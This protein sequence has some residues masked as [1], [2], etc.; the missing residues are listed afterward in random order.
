M[1]ETTLDKSHAAMQAAPENDALRLR[2]YEDLCDADVY[3]LLD[4]EPEGDSVKP[5]VVEMEGAPF[6]LIFD[7]EDRLSD[8]TGRVAPYAGLPGRALVQMM[9]GQGCGLALNLRVASSAMLIPADGVD[10]L[11]TTLDHAP[12][13]TQARLVAI[14]PPKSLPEAVLDALDRKLSKTAGLAETAYLVAAEYEDGGKG[15]VLGFVGADDSAHGAL[16]HAAGEALTF[17]GIDAGTMDVVFIGADE[18]MARRLERVGLR[19]DLPKIQRV[20]PD[21]PMAPGADP[22][23][24]PKLR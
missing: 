1:T 11:A 12:E 3:V 2:F 20:T 6:A 17:S 16:A 10:W 8:F 9:A 24:P 13:Q 23:K 14:T 18:E 7:T 22:N 4:A 15:H 5:T 19:F 21:V